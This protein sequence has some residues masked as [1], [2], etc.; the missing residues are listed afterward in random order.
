MLSTPIVE[1][2]KQIVKKMGSTWKNAIPKEIPAIIPRLASI[3]IVIR[4]KQPY[5]KYIDFILQL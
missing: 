1:L 4:E 3:V 2:S 5:K